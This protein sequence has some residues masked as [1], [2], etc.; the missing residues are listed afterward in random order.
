MT[1]AVNELTYW[2]DKESA[3]VCR[4]PR[5]L[6]P[7]NQFFMTLIKLK[8]NLC[9]KDIAYHF[10]ISEPIVSRY[11]TTWICFLYQQLQEISW[12][13]DVDQ[14]VTTLPTSFRDKYQ[15]AYAIIDVTI[16]ETPSD[17]H[18]QLSTWNSYKSHCLQL[19]W[20]YSLRGGLY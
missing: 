15:T 5:K 20:H 4:R 1:R 12:M 3:G 8:L 13:P 11:L 19:F 7:H 17:L 10:G 18:L 2:G 6:S 9:I 14:V 16:L